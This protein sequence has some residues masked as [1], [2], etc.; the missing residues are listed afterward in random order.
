MMTLSA[1]WDGQSRIGAL[2]QLL[3]G[4][5]DRVRQ[6]YGYRR[7]RRE[8]RHPQEPKDCIVGYE[9]VQRSGRDPQ[10]QKVGTN[11]KT[12]CIYRQK[13]ETFQQAREL[14][15]ESI[16]FYNHERIQLK[17]GV[18]P[19][20]RR[21]SALISVFPA[22]ASFLCCPHNLGLRTPRPAAAI[23]PQWKW[24]TCRNSR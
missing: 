5:Q 14:V 3:K 12:E 10:A 23:S 19:L 13:I 1:A 11:F 22:A 15:G 21:H 7:M 9:E 18:A 16:Y 24:L 6:T 4:Q 20:A 17:T 8:S 2:G